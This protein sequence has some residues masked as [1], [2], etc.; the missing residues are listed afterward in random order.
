MGV[1]LARS[2]KLRRFSGYVLVP[3]PMVKRFE[4]MAGRCEQGN[5]QGGILIGSHR[6]PHIELT[7]LTMP[8]P[9]DR[10]SPT[11][12]EKID[13]A[14]QRAADKTWRASDGR[15]TYIGEWHTHPGGRAAP[16]FRDRRTWAQVSAGISRA[17]AFIIVAP[18]MW[19]LFVTE[20][21]LTWSARELQIHSYGKA[22][23]VFSAVPGA[24]AE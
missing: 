6:G 20:R 14:H 21:R 10:G 3:Y 5:E 18:G 4:R 13:P 9:T 17:A 16:S 2:A 12:F 11:S 19:S 22:N 24:G 7:D 8:G 1:L 15:R 23:L